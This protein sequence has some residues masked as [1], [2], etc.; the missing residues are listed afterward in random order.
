MLVLYVPGDT[1]IKTILKGLY[2]AYSG[3][4]VNDICRE[5][6][7]AVIME[8]Q[9]ACSLIEIAEDARYC[10][11][12]M[13]EIS[14]ETYDEMLCVLPPRD[15]HNIGGWSC[16]RMSEY[17]TSNITGHYLKSPDGRCFHKQCRDTT[18]YAELIEQAKELM[19]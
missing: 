5:Y 17:W 4:W 6:P 16:F 14:P 19:K 12:P 3:E 13:T 15:W 8:F 18:K 7:G 10:G 2:C 11:N 9:T 1:G